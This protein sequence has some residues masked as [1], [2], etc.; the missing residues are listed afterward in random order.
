MVT[1]AQHAAIPQAVVTLSDDATGSAR[2][3]LADET[4]T[5]QFAQVPPGLYSLKVESPGFT[6]LVKSN[7]RLEVNNPATLDCMLEVGTVGSTVNVEASVESINTVDASLGNAFSEKQIRELPLQ[8]RNVV[9]LL[10]IQPGVTQTGEVLGARRDQNNVTL[11]GVDVNN[12]QN[13]GITTAGGNGSNTGNLRTGGF[14]S[15]LPIPLDS[16]QEFRVTVAGQGA[17]QGRSSGG[18]VS[19]VTKS[20][21]NEL[22]GSLYEYNRNTALTANDWFNNRSSLK[23]TALVRNQFGVSV[24]GPVLK[25]RVFFFGNWERRIDASAQSVTRT[26]PSES[27]KQGILTFRASDGSTQTLSPA[28]IASLDPLKIGYSSAMKTVLNSYPVGNDPTLGVDR[29][30]NFSGLRFNTPYKQDDSVYVAKMDFNID[31]ARNHTVSLRGTLA[32]LAQDSTVAQFPGQAPASVML[33][34]SRG[35]AAMHT[36]VVKPSLINVATVGYTRQGIRQS[37]ALGDSLSF[38]SISS[39]TNFTRPSARITPTTNI[40]DDITWTKGQHTVTTGINF[41]FIRNARTS[42]SNSFASYSFSRNTLLGLGG[43]LT[44]IVQTYIQQRSGNSALRLSDATSVQRAFGNLLGL[45]NQYSVTYQFD[46]SGKAIP[47]GSAA[48]REFAMNEYEGYVQDSWRA[49]R[50][51]TLT[52]GLRYSN[53]SVPYETQG[54]EVATTYPLNQY[55]ADRVAASAAGTPNNQIANA[56]LTYDLAGAANG[57]P[58]WYGRDNN[59]FGPRVAFAYSPEKQDGLMSHFLGRGSVL[60]GGFGLLYDRYGSDMIVNLD[61]GGSPGLASS[62]TQPNNTNFSTA[63]RYNGV[64]SLPA[65]PVAPQ[66]GFPFTPPTIT[67]G[68]DSGVAI[69][70][71]LIAP[72]SMVVNLS[73]GKELPGGM[74]LEIGYAG[75]F[76]RDSLL[77]ADINQALTQFKDPASGKTWAQA[78]GEVRQYLDAGVTP[79]MVKANPSLIRPVAFFENM[80]PALTNLYLPGSATANYFDVVYNQNAGSD[81]DGLN[82]LDRVRT[83]TRFPNC[84]TRT[85]C[86]TFFPLQKAG[87]QTWVNWGYGNY[88]AA[89]LSVRKRFSKGYSFDFNYTWAHSIDNSSG[90]EGGAGTSGAILQDAFNP[91]AFRGS[92]DFDIR[93]NITM[94]ALAELPFGRNKAFLSGIPG[95]TNQIVGGWQVMLIGRYNTGLPSTISNGG[96]YSTNYLNSS[97][98]IRK[99]GADVRQS[100]GYNQNGNP[101]LFANTDAVNGFVSQYPGGTGA[102]EIVRLPGLTNFDLSVGKNFT[103]P[104]E[105]HRVQ[106]RAEAFNAFNLVNFYNPTLSLSTPSRFGEFAA[107]RP[108]RVL[109]LSLRYEF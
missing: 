47:L 79:A 71:D 4:G 103:T 86:N 87:T 22:H 34:N 37:G 26:L 92:S 48:Q 40:A 55:F 68:F 77:Q 64:S 98:A 108:A 3:V 81:L 52:F 90:A 31:Q 65:L 14:N 62:M 16:V 73:Y 99:A 69:S 100:I 70:P 51:L 109:Q 89:V 60:R 33:D 35:L 106:F 15:A 54:I 30:L 74:S 1:D 85:G 66:G 102:R 80:F 63:A 28:E 95:W 8:T 75:R 67:G 91:D 72:R 25:N 39:P 83:D 43:D 50:D 93:H 94:N 59:N 56:A 17:N 45:I 107:A 7:V 97:L 12:N 10:S 21:T 41:R 6:V 49:R 18:Q 76:S 36:W 42:Y 78:A 38:D 44:S 82:Q 27:L 32:D 46:R 58:G 29:G 84:I 53:S 101:S 19:L 9:E 104:W 105:G 61:S 20:G 96:V 88:N 2:K 11:D 57:R 13:S 5:Y 24:G 23:R